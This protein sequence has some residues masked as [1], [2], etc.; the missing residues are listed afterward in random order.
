MPYYM[1]QAS[2]SSD[3]WGSQIK[4]PQ[5]HAEAIRPSIEKLG[6]KLDDV[7][8]TF[9]EYDIVGIVQFP[10]NQSA[11]ALSI[12][13]ASSGSVKSLKTTPLMT[14]EEGIE[15]VNKAGESNYRPPS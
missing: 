1:I 7:Y 14:I 2:Y 3:A 4:N 11:A 13:A 10:D 8:F 9:G 6:G 5:N 15:A 12:A